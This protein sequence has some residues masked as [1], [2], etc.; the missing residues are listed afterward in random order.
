MAQISI[1]SLMNNEAP[2]YPE[3]MVRPFR[4]ELVNAG[5]KELMTPADVDEALDKKDDK[6]I[7]VMLN[8]VCGCSARSARPG[9]IISL[10]NDKI[11]DER[12]TLFA[13][14]EKEAVSHFREK[15]LTGITPTSP[16]IALFK[17]GEL[18]QYIPRH[19]IERM[20][21]GQIAG[22]LAEAYDKF[23]RDR[24]STRLNS[25]HGYI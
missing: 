25:S 13:G 10:L 21:A 12:V 4:Q 6:I 17:N 3:E 16:N 9:T 22:H 2:S 5:F 18:L 15:F 1:K 14:M 8:S 20:S 24:K 11:P 7:L 23:C 19:E